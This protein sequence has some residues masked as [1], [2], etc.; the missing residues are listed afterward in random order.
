MAAAT[1]FRIIIRGRGGHAAAPHQTVDPIVVSAHAITALQTVVSRSIDPEAPAVVTIGRRTDDR[2]RRRQR[3][4][5]GIKDAGLT[6]FVEQ[7]R[8]RA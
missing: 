7:F 2:S 6:D 4:V 1:H 8:S 5:N 3:I